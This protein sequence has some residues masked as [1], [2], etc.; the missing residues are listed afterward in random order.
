M[1]LLRHNHVVARDSCRGLNAALQG[2]IG[3]GQLKCRR[4]AAHTETAGEQRCAVMPQTLHG[5]AELVGRRLSAVHLA[6]EPLSAGA[7]LIELAGQALDLLLG[8][9]DRAG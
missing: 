1:D 3:I 9:V 2:V 4:H 8:D 7:G 6:I 5:F